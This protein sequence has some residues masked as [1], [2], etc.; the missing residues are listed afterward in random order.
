MTQIPNSTFACLENTTIVTSSLQWTCLTTSA[1]TSPLSTE[2]SCHFQ[3]AR[4]ICSHPRQRML[5]KACSSTT[6]DGLEPT[7]TPS[8]CGC[9]PRQST[10]FSQLPSP[11]RARTLRAEPLS[12]REKSTG[13]YAFHNPHPPPQLRHI[14]AACARLFKPNIGR[15]STCWSRCAFQ[16]TCD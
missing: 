9:G 2:S 10:A 13:T 12:S 3:T 16:N 4:Y 7:Q 8:Q 11:S 5:S 6:L 15:T 14:L 1:L